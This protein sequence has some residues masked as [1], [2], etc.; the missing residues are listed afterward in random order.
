MEGG[1]NLMEALWTAITTVISKFV[2]ALGTVST[3]L[4]TNEIFQIMLGAIIFSVAVRYVYSFAKSI[5][6]GGRRRR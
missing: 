6:G 4:I 1:A 5:K 2:A 3:A